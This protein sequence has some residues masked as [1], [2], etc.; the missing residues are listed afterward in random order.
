MRPMLRSLLP[1]LAL[2]L[3]PV[4][5]FGQEPVDSIAQ[6]QAEVWLRR[7]TAVYD[8]GP[9]A[10]K[11]KATVELGGG[12]QKFRSQVRG[13]MVYL[14]R[15]HSNVAVMMNRPD[16]MGRSHMKSVSDGATTWTQFTTGSQ[17]QVFKLDTA[18]AERMAERG[19]ALPGGG[20]DP[21]AQ[22][23]ALTSRMDFELEGTLK[24]EKIGL[25]GRY[26]AGG[27]QEGQPAFRE[28]RLV[29]DAKTAFPLELTMGEAV[30][31]EIEDFEFLER[32]EIDMGLFK[33]SP[34]EGAEVK[35]LGPGIQ[36]R[37]EGGQEPVQAAAAN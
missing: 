20:I 16:G 30:K 26:K 3:T 5:S 6:G 29:L 34:P 8:Q 28:M 10:F 23:R 4:S 31:I 22:I 1:A 33:Y 37:L 32:G 7:M 15:N 18:L 14:D 36:A 12:E 21:V 27:P 9:F 24:G 25:V 17:T 35:D 13:R 2:V 19:M 11:L